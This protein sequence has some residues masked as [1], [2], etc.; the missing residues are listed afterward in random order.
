VIR[1]V[2]WRDVCAFDDILVQCGVCA[3][4]DGVQIAIF[5]TRDGVY[6]IDNADPIGKANVLARGIVGDLSGQ[7]VVASP[8]YKHHYNLA[9]GQCLED[10]AVRVATHRVRVHEGR[11]QVEAGIQRPGSV[12]RRPRLVLVGNGMAGMRALEELLAL[13]PTRYD[14]TVFGA[15]ARGG[16]NRVGLSSVLTGEKTYSE[17]AGHDLEWYES[18]GIT[19]RAGDPVVAI[20]RVRRVVTAASGIECGYDRLLL[21]TGSTPVALDVP[22]HDLAGV[23]TFRNI[24]DVEEMLRIASA[25]GRAV[26]IGGGLLGVEAAA[27]LLQRGMSVT[28]V[29]NSPNLLN[30][31]LDAEAGCFLAGSLEKRGITLRL[32]VRTE[33]IEGDAPGAEGEPSAESQRNAEGQQ[34][35]RRVVLDD[36]SVF[37]ADLVVTAVGIRPNIALAKAAG[38][39]CDHGILVDDTMQTFDPRIWAIG[40]CVQHRR[41]TFGL[42]AP[43][44]EQARVCAVHL[45]ELGTARYRAPMPSALL[46]VS[47]VHVFSAGKLESGEGTESIVLRDAR[48][49]VYK[50]L[51]LR[52]NRVEGAVLYGDVSDGAW[53]CELMNSGADV[54]SMRD[55]LLFGSK[56]AGTPE[57]RPRAEA[58]PAPQ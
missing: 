23:L 15:E 2:A 27:G 45:A 24:D 21:A 13:A 5:R 26:V 35:L 30:R 37:E 48:R 19:L 7:P 51:V 10:S 3:F 46:K 52:G 54:G 4:V 40:E 20:D 39:Q 18:R 36:G 44:W 16:Y 12:R 58:S 32:G 34:R 29:H 9:T 28:L 1:A 53:Y 56:A 6:A 22:G 31:Q 25:G 49:G 8:L 33:R 11:V 55:A 57:A 47:G 41:T 14:I 50:R 42:V 17:I 43:L 38:I